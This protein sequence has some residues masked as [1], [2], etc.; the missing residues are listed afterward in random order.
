MLIAVADLDAA[1]ELFA[2]RHGLTS[3]EGGRHPGWGT[4]NRIVPL[5]DSY[6]ELVAVVDAGE[7][8][9]SVFGRWVAAGASAEGTPLGWVV[10]TDELDAT[11]GRLGLTIGTGSRRTPSGELVEW[12][13]A[14]IEQAAAE[15]VLPFFIEWA[16]GTRLP[17]S[18][19]GDTRLSKL[20]LTGDGDRLRA[21]LGRHSLPIGVQPGPPAV[22]QIVLRSRAEE[23]V[24]GEP[25]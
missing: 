25:A 1:A 2:T 3:I 6:L 19:G 10:R 24:L 9:T 4:A 21:W 22:R 20:C 11:A 5:G 8:P 14:G 7:A 23:L 16:P 18:A 17:G 13:S 12:R 15:P